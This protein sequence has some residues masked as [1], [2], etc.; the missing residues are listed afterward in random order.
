M[1][2][3]RMLE[4]NFWN[5]DHW[6]A[7]SL[8]NQPIVK[9]GDPKQLVMDR[10]TLIAFDLDGTLIEVKSM[11]DQEMCELLCQL[12][13]AKKVAI[14][15]GASYSYFQNHVLKILKALVSPDLLGRLYLFPASSSLCYSYRRGWSL[16]YKEVLSP[17]DKA[18][19]KNSFKKVSK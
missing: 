5:L 18:Q 8:L 4:M 17:Q 10:K 11:I 3:M 16:V 2:V 13:T 9:Q 12:L 14:M 19:I 7:D 6:Y 15:S 1:T